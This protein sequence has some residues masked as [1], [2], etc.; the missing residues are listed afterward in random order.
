MLLHHYGHDGRDVK[1]VDTKSIVFDFDFIQQM[2]NPSFIESLQS[3]IDLFVQHLVTERNAGMAV[4]Y[5]VE[6]VGYTFTFV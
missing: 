2:T 1:K 5:Y 3:K 4:I 6:C